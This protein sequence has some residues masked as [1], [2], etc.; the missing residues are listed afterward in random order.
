M[1]YGAAK[2]GQQLPILRVLLP[3]A[4]YVDGATLDAGQLALTDRG[5]Y[6]S[7]YGV[8]QVG[9]PISPGETLAADLCAVGRLVDENSRIE[10]TGGVEL[11]LDRS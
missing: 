10:Y 4:V 2:L 7:S 8:N 9:A 5:A 6:L 1:D 11:A 3:S